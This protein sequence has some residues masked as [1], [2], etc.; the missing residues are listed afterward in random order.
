MNAFGIHLRRLNLVTAFAEQSEIIFQELLPVE[1]HP[2]R[3][4]KVVVRRVWHRIA[5]K[6][7]RLRC[8]AGLTRATH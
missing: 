7:K 3:R 4:R 1:S 5:I 8:A 6:F 2:L